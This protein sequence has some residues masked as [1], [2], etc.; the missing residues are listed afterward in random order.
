MDKAPAISKKKIVTLL[1]RMFN[2]GIR[3][4]IQTIYCAE[5]TL[6]N[7]KKVIMARATKRISRVSASIREDSE[8]AANI[9][10]LLSWKAKS[11][12]TISNTA[13]II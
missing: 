10:F 3:G 1:K 12:H 4:Q 11:R 6:L 13:A 8:F 7:S 2:K 9:S 5:K